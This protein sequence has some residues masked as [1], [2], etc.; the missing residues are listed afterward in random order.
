MHPI[1]LQLYIESSLVATYWDLYDATWATKDSGE[2]E[3]PGGIALH[4][5]QTAELGRLHIF[6]GLCR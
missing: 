5:Y 6:Q 2:L 1:Q 3:N 4:D